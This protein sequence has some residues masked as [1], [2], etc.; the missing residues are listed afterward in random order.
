MKTFA[1]RFASLRFPGE[2][3]KEFA[4]RLNTTQASISRY[5]RGQRPDSITL[6]KIADKTGVALDWLLTGKEPE[7]A[8][9]VEGIMKKVSARLT[10][11]HSDK[12]WL[13]VSLT[14]FDEI[15]A[16]SGEERE[17]IKYMLRDMLENPKHR[18]EIFEFWN[19]L[20]FKVKSPLLPIPKR[21][22]RRK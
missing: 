14:Y 15:K 21:K 20:R 3:Q 7:I 5:L 4:D 18:K 11:P 22:R 2:T 6:Q 16:F 9:E 8:K 13:E 17:Y 1:E 10:K 12:D 19:Y